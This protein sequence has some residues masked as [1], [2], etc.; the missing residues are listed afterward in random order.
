MICLSSTALKS[1]CSFTFRFRRAFFTRK[2]GF[3]KRRCRLLQR[4]KLA[5]PAA[6]HA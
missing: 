1:K 4:H 6:I 3:F 5:P 2:P